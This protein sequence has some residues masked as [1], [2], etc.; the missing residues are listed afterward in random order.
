MAEPDVASPEISELTSFLGTKARVAASDGRVFTGVFMCIDKQKNVILS[1]AEELSV[2]VD[3]ETGE[4]K[5][6]RRYVGLIMVPGKHMNETLLC[7]HL[8]PCVPASKHLVRFVFLF[9]NSL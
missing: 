6:E 4:K 7:G 1:G 3:E 9:A 5:D 8:S 2:G